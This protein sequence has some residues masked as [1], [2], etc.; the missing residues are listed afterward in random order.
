MVCTA[1]SAVRVHSGS[2][3]LAFFDPSLRAFRDERR[4]LSEGPHAKT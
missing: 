4:A 2:Q 1:L 3:T